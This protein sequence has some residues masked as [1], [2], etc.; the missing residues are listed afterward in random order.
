MW[1]A[2]ITEAVGREPF[3]PDRAEPGQP[4]TTEEGNSLPEGAILR[5]SDAS[6]CQWFIRTDESRHSL[7]TRGVDGWGTGGQYS[8]RGA[9]FVSMPNPETLDVPPVTHME[10]E[11]L[12]A[13]S[14]IRDITMPH[15]RW[16]KESNGRWRQFTRGAEDGAWRGS[17]GVG[18]V[19][20]AFG[21]PTLR[22]EH[23]PGISSQ[24]AFT[25]APE[26]ALAV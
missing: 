15:H 20:T 26:T 25:R 14:I 24:P 11:R 23:V 9:Q 22:I 12:P 6:I 2:G 1:R 13:G 16:Y 5:H 21:L 7:R 17:G 3:D 10:L 18:A 4:I 19:S 8:N